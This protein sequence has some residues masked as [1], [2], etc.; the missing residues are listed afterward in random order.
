VEPVIFGRGSDLV[1]KP[2]IDVPGRPVD[3]NERGTVASF[4]RFEQ[5]AA[6]A[7]SLRWC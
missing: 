1:T 4:G 7:G 2:V 5:I 3:A 6:I